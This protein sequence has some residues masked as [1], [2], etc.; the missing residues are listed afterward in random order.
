MMEPRNG[1]PIASYEDYL[2]TY[3]PQRTSSPLFQ[4]NTPKEMGILLAVESLEKHGG[5]LRPEVE[6]I[7]PAEPCG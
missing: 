1:T 3:Y 2:T 5:D 7:R 6:A 4:T